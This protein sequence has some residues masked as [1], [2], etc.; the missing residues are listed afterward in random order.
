MLF[1]Q[2]RTFPQ[3]WNTGEIYHIWISKWMALFHNS[4][5][6]DGNI[7]ILKCSFT[8]LQL[9]WPG[10][11]AVP[12]SYQDYSWV[13]GICICCFF[14]LKCSSF[15]FSHSLLPHSYQFL[16]RCDYIKEVFPWPSYITKT[17]LCLSFYIPLTH[18]SSF[19]LSYIYYLSSSLK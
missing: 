6:K 5:I 11:F 2:E 19:H 1:C 10:H 18:F 7:F 13:E 16:F 4:F 15:I 17:L 12:S 8:L 3:R 9:H 14:C